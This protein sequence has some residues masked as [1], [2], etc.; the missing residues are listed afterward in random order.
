MSFDEL[1]SEISAAFEAGDW[2]IEEFTED[3]EKKLGTGSH[4]TCDPPEGVSDGV[5][6]LVGGI[7]ADD[8]SITASQLYLSGYNDNINIQ[9]A[10]QCIMEVNIPYINSFN[11]D[12]QLGD[13]GIDLQIDDDEMKVW[14]SGPDITDMV[15]NLRTKLCG[16]VASYETQTCI[17]KY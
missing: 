17:R 16:I 10:A 1:R 2:E 3:G 6:A 5:M 15:R 9:E 13:W 4:I 7:T 11:T 14:R 8:K 12:K